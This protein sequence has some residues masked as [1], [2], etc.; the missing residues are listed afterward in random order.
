MK[1]CPRCGSHAQILVNLVGCLTNSCRNY[2]AKWATAWNNRNKPKYDHHNMKHVFLGNFDKSTFSFD[3]YHWK[4]PQGL[5]ICFARHGDYGVPDS[6]YYV[7][8]GETEIGS[9]DRGPVAKC[10]KEIQAALQEALKQ[11]RGNKA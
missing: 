3:L 7:D 11:F 10:S 8:E 1:Y 4:D 6:C 9:V 2:D 5:N